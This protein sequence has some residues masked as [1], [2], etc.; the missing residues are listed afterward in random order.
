MEKG[1][2][3]WRT[4]EDRIDRQKN[5]TSVAT[6]MLLVRLTPDNQTHVYILMVKGRKVK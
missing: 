5:S 6:D 3:I 1:R 4:G 2:E